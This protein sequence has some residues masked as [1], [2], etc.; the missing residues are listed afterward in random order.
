MDTHEARTSYL[1][2]FGLDASCPFK[3]R[4]M[5]ST[6]RKTCRRMLCKSRYLNLVS[7]LVISILQ[8]STCLVTDTIFALFVMWQGLSICSAR[9]TSLFVFPSSAPKISTHSNILQQLI[10]F[11]S[12]ELSNMGARHGFSMD[13]R[14]DWRVLDE[15]NLAS[16]WLLSKRLSILAAMEQLILLLLLPALDFTPSVILIHR[17]P[18]S[19]II[20]IPR[21]IFFWWAYAQLVCNGGGW[22]AHANAV[23][24]F[25]QA[26]ILHKIAHYWSRVVFQPFLR[27]I[28]KFL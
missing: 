5:K 28:L 16:S 3:T 14:V 18:T 12:M 24:G 4:W 8:C 6:V 20:L 13:H 1:G 11:S 21:Y 22:R 15:A 17:A 27:R 25:G 7:S 26:G 9:G 19:N 23:L 10:S 2:R